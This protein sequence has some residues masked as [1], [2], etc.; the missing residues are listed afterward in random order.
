MKN[1]ISKMK[2]EKRSIA[3]NALET[4]I[5]DPRVE[6]LS[7]AIREDQLCTQA[8]KTLRRI[9]DAWKAAFKEVVKRHPDARTTD[10]DNFLLSFQGNI[11]F[12]MDEFEREIDTTN[13]YSKPE[14]TY[15]LEANKGRRGF[16]WSK[17][18]IA[19]WRQE[20]D[21][22]L[23]EMIDSDKKKKSRIQE[24]QAVAANSRSLIIP[25]VK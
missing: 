20:K 7:A 16:G 2:P 5:R 6:V 1:L 13:H 10:I 25:S 8:I 17:E 21:K 11:K 3:K 18:F 12:D 4:F 19:E 23:K 14:D 22:F 15:D 24:Q 9:H